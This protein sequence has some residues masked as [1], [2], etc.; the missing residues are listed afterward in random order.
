MH[1]RTKKS[2]RVSP[3]EGTIVDTTARK[4]E[5]DSPSSTAGSRQ[6]GACI[7]D[8][9][10]GGNGSPKMNIPVVGVE[11]PEKVLSG[12]CGGPI[13]VK[14]SAGTTGPVDTIF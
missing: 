7:H 9:L 14:R 13:Y 6:K 1:I 4:N 3:G 11:F 10:S 5:R 12:N 2:S 8:D